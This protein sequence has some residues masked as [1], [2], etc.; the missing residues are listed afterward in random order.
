MF[1]DTNDKIQI[2]KYYGMSII[3]T[4]HSHI[5]I[6]GRWLPFQNFSGLLLPANQSFRWLPGEYIFFS[7]KTLKVGIFCSRVFKI[8]LRMVKSF[9]NFDRKENISWGKKE[10]QKKIKEIKCI[11]V[12]VRKDWK[13]F[14]IKYKELIRMNS[15]Q[16]TKFLIMK[17]ENYLIT[18]I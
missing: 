10:H 9:S 16:I 15:D 5:P 11:R 4:L 8:F 3:Y 17:T 14:F 2:F 6:W 18:Y 7:E 12:W 1:K 13:T